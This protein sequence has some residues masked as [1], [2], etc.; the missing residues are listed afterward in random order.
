MPNPK[1]PM[2]RTSILYGMVYT[3]SH[4]P[5]FPAKARGLHLSQGYRLLP[6]AIGKSKTE[7]RA[8][9]FLGW[10]CVSKDVLVGHKVS[11]CYHM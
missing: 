8:L 7:R 3:R 1:A 9:L 6:P 5:W 10:S 2:A 11:E 4:Q